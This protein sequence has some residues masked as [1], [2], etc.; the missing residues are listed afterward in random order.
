MFFLQAVRSARQASASEGNLSVRVLR[1]ARSTFWTATVWT[2]EASMKQFMLAG[3]H[4]GVMR[5]LLDWCDEAA[6]VHWV[7]DA[8][9][10]PTWDEAYARLRG[11]GRRSKVNYP[12]AAHTNFD[13]LNRVWES[14][15]K[16]GS[17]R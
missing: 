4:R 15:A 12:S 7:L 13:F 8:A 11:D 10:P 9:D 3:V 5:K 2:S 6:V 16:C 17:S 1:D 14:P